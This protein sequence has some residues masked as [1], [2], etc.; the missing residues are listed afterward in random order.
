MLYLKTG[1]DSVTTSRKFVKLYGYF[2]PPCVL[3]QAPRT[4]RAAR[5]FRIF[6]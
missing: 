5:R 2:H 1:K 6:R 4:P 3:H